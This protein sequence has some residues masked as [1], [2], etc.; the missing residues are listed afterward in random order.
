MS[1]KRL[2]TRQN[3]DA[4]HLWNGMSYLLSPRQRYHQPKKSG[5]TWKPNFLPVKKK[6]EVQDAR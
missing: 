5:G 6:E 2:K 3:E 1:D 4:I